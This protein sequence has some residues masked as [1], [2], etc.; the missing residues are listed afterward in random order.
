MGVSILIDHFGRP[1][2][3]KPI[4]LELLVPAWR[5]RGAGRT[6]IVDAQTT[7]PSLR[8]PVGYRQL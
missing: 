8:S 1:P 5:I 4:S 2:P 3:V 6:T 7:T